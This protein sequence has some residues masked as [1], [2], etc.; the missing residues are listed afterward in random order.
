MKRSRFTESQIVDILK[1]ADGGL[2][3]SEI[4]RKHNRD[5]ADADR[6]GRMAASRVAQPDY[7]VL[8]RRTE[9]GRR[10]NPG[11]Y[12]SGTNTRR[13]RGALAP[14]LRW[15]SVVERRGVAPGR[16]IARR[17]RGMGE[18][19]S[20]RAEDPLHIS[21]WLVSEG[22]DWKKAR[23]GASAGH[24]GVRER[25]TRGP[26][27]ATGRHRKCVSLPRGRARW[28]GCRRPCR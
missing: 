25:S 6:R 9:G 23:A 19:G 21:R 10:G 17:F 24:A 3:V 7:S 1:E 5:A 4:W 11:V 28:P 12:L 27:I 20:Q 22:A 2:P 14:L 16:A 18:P 15:C 8:S 26:R 13:L